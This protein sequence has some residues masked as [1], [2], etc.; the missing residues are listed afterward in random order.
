M[1]NRMMYRMRCW[2]RYRMRCMR[3][4][5]RHRIMNMVAI[6]WYRMQH[7]FRISAWTKMYKWF[8]SRFR[9]DSK[10]R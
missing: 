9:S 7:L 6:Y 2:M 8:W 4:W 5:M 1:I 10:R 3:Y